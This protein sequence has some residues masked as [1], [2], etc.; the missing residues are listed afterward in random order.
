MIICRL[1]N[2][3]RPYDLLTKE[4]TAIVR[5]KGGG[6]R[7]RFKDIIVSQETRCH[8]KKSAGETVGE[9]GWARARSFQPIRD[10]IDYYWRTKVT[11][12]ES[13]EDDGIRSFALL[14]S[15]TER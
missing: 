15:R 14:R 12:H 9:K 8:L 2:K 4:P 10:E 6:L 7:R 5:K 11:S 13:E 1:Y 3:R